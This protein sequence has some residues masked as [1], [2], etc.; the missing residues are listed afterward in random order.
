MQYHIVSTGFNCEKYIDDFINNIFKQG[1]FNLTVHI[2]DDA[3]IDKTW[4]KLKKFKKKYNNIRLYQ[5]K[6]RMGAAYNR[7]KIIK[8]INDKDSVIVLVDLDDYL[9]KDALKTVNKLYMGNKYLYATYGNWVNQYEKQN[10]NICYPES[11]GYKNKLEKYLNKVIIR[12]RILKSALFDRF[13]PF[14]KRDENNYIFYPRD[15]IKNRSY[16]QCKSFLY[17]HLRT[18]KRFLFDKFTEKDFQDDNGKWLQIRTDVPLI[19]ILEQCKEKN[20]AHIAKPIY[21]Y[22]QKP[23]I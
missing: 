15:V 5:N 23:R 10:Y 3:S 2:Y 12:L 21:L 17:T 22:R 6:K 11:L 9:L 7:Y 8:S 4:E 14:E 13:L 1:N 19:K 20:I 18:F 16:R